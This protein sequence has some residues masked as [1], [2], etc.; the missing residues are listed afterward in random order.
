MDLEAIYSLV[1]SNLS[2]VA[3]LF[4]PYF[5]GL[6]SIRRFEHTEIRCLMLDDQSC[7]GTVPV[8]GNLLPF[9]V[10]W[11]FLDPSQKLDRAAT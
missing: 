3:T 7:P 5:G 6:Y 8:V 9:Q 4:G 1:S 11:P 10:I 2:S